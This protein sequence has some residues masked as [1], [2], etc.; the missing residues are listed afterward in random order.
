[1]MIEAILALL[2]LV[3]GG[4]VRAVAVTGKTR[5]T[6]APDIPTMAEL[7]LPALDFGAWWAMWGPPDMPAD[8]VATLNGWVN[9]AVVALAADG[10]LD[11]L[12]IAPAAE[13][14]AAF[15]QFIAADLERSA[16]L[17]KAAHFE[18]Q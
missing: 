7:G 4:A 13:T 16:T 1:M 11:K 9:D 15:A 10:R 2:P 8:L 5:S 12:G 14:P 18:P 6:L 17:L 3:K